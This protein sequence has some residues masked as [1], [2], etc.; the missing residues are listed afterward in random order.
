MSEY[1]PTTED[2]RGW[3]AGAR[4]V[5]GDPDRQHPDMED[6]FDRWLAAHD[7]EVRAEAWEVGAKNMMQAIGDTYGTLTFIAP[8]NP[9][10]G[11]SEAR[12]GV[13]AEEPGWAQEIR[14]MHRVE[15][16]VKFL[17]APD[18]RHAEREPIGEEEYFI[19]DYDKTTWPCKTQQILGAAVPVKQEGAEKDG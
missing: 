16:G 14:A 8:H 9:F 1:T 13:V 5:F 4:Y 11:D 12:A 17:Y 3:Y 2:V 10:R 7:A 6:E 19:C 15:R 18:D